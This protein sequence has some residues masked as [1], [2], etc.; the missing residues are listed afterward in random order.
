M[1]V[2]EALRESRNLSGKSQE[3]M[4]LE[5]GIARKTVQNWERG[6]SEP[7]IGQAVAWFKALDIS[8]LPYLLQIVHNDMDRI[9]GK[10]DFNKLKASL[11][12][13]LQELPEEGVRQLLYLFYGDHGSS[14]RAILNMVTAHLQTPMEARVT[15]GSVI[16]KNYEMAQKKHIL[17]AED[18]VQPNVELLKKA[19]NMGEE[20]AVKNLDTYILSDVKKIY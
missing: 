9:N 3:Y 13:L 16:L 19:I 20:A 1:D 11:N 4:A 12:K 18:H 15:Q 17:T 8:P 10:D 2:C 5:I 7:T 14:P 6:T